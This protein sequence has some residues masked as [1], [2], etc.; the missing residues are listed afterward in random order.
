MLIDCDTGI[1]DSLALLFAMRRPDVRIMGIVASFGNTTAEQAAENTLRLIKLADSGYEI[2][3]AIG[4]DRA[5]NGTQ[6]VPITHIHGKNGIGNVE[7]P[8][9]DQKV[10]DRNGVDFILDVIGR[11][12]NEITLVTL[13]RLTDI[14]LALEKD[15]GLPKKVKNLVVMGGTL[16]HAGNVGPMSE[17]NITGDAEAADRVLSAGFNITV[18]GLD[19]TAKTHLTEHT[20][21]CLSRYCMPKNRPAVQY[22]CEAI[23]NVYFPFNRKQNNCLDYCPVHDPLAMLAAIDPTP[24]TFRKLRVRVECGGA[25]SRGRLIADMREQPIDAPFTE[26]AVDIEPE[27]ALERIIAAFYDHTFEQDRISEE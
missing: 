12:P 20:L 3:V 2:P 19:V 11:N 7:L 14:A 1:D 25:W 16:F 10:I 9:S 26:V 23:R 15:P 18:V 13:G 21:D 4:T 22:L 8:A 5:L 27:A 6:Y 17:A 24:F